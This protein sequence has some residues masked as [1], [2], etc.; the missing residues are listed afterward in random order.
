MEVLNGSQELTGNISSSGKVFAALIGQ[1]GPR[2]KDGSGLTILGAY[3]TLEQL[4]LAHPTGN[5]GDSYMI[6]ANLY[7]WDAI[8]NDWINV[9][10][11]KGP[12][13][14]I[15][16]KGDTGAQGE[17]GEQGPQ[18][19]QGEQGVQGPKGE[20]GEKGDQGPQGEAGTD[21][22]VSPTEPTGDNREKVWMQKGKNLFDM[23]LIS[24]TDVMTNDKK[25]TLTIANNASNVGYVDTGM[26][27]SSV[28]KGIVGQTYISSFEN[29][30]S[31]AGRNDRFYLSGVNSYIIKNTPFVLT[32]EMLD[33]TIILYGGY[34]E[35]STIKNMQI[36]QN[37]TVTSYEAY[38]EPKIYVKNDNDVYEEFISKSEYVNENY[39]NYIEYNENVTT[40]H[41]TTVYRKDNLVFI[42]FDLTG[43]FTEGEIAIGTLKKKTKFGTFGVGRIGTYE[44]GA[45]AS[46]PTS[47]IMISNGPVRIYSPIAGTKIAGTV[48]L[49]LD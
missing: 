16:P 30:F 48:I 18:G 35:T 17:K 21:V 27:L 31:M 44:L 43:N 37:S 2:G 22:V 38:I 47:I 1:A 14:D 49:L 45:I 19:E 42:N 46:R 32:Q 7:V 15:G 10:N 11:I 5:K 12:Q 34:N 36:E 25:G 41:S 20:K 40:V 9:G 6:D 4:K 8:S 33:S 28:F 3:D 29:T 13:G 24:N 23:N 26:K 39:N